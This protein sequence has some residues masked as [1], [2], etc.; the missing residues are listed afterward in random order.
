M[1]VTCSLVVVVLAGVGVSSPPAGAT[2]VPGIAGNVIRIGGVFDGTSFAGAQAGFM[3]R[4]DRANRTH[5]LGKYKIDVVGIDDD[6]D[7]AQT[8]LSDVQNLVERDNV[9]AL[10]PVISTGFDKASASVAAAHKVPY[11]GPGFSN[12][13]CTP[14]TW[15]ISPIGCAIG[16]T[17]VNGMAVDQVAHA[18]GKPV[19]Q[20]RWAFV[21]L[22]IPTGTQA[23]NDYATAVT[24]E[25]GKVVYNKAVIPANVGN[26]AP[27]INSIE[28]TRPDVIW[29]IVGSQAIALKSAIKASGFS[30]AIVDNALYGPGILKV[31][32]V[33]SALEG[34]Y[35]EA[36]TPVLEENTPYVQK[37]V[38]DYKA[39]GQ[40]VSA[41]TF[42]GE[43]AYMTADLLVAALKKA[44]PNFSNIHSVMT[45]GFSYVPTVGGFPVKY[46][47]MY[48]A[49]TDCGTTVKVVNGAF[50]IATPFQCS[51]HY[52]KAPTGS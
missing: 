12:S 49:P 39:S 26:I 13:F 11:F 50:T 3:A 51:T 28:A 23:D 20:L 42:G 14:N 35:V 34:T 25:G 10:A 45:K 8:D 6:T 48:S 38:A 41:I 1:V 37:M 27:V 24:H 40:P 43:S 22:A 52:L 9:F 21:G 36:T 46:P 7:N 44:N 32:A 29:T 47:F 19:D 30:G 4:I 31:S 17:S 33:A 18:V 16:G 5:E 15:G 2:T